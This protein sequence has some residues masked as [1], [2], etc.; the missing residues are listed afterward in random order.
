MELKQN[1]DEDLV[2]HMQELI[3]DMKFGS[4]TLVVQDGQVIQ[5]EKNE[6]IRLK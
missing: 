2:K 6:K 1:Q 5:V 4:I 3:G